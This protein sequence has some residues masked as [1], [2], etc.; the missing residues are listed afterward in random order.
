[1]KYT[2]DHSDTQPK[3]TD[4]GHTG[5]S[6]NHSP[7][8]KSDAHE[9]HKDTHIHS[10]T[11]RKTITYTKPVVHRIRTKYGDHE[12]QKDKQDQIDHQINQSDKSKQIGTFISI[13]TR[14]FYHKQL[15]INYLIHL[16]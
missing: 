6:V 13:I 5:K 10:N 12:Q 8:R 2:N 14:I 11:Q 7:H 1:M 9:S 15:N 16:N 3:T 4:H